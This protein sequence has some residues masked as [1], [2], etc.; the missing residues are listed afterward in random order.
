[1][2]I[3]LKM[4]MKNKFYNKVQKIIP[5][6]SQ[7][8]SK[9]PEL[10][11]PKNWPGFYNKAKGVYVY[12]LKGNKFLDMSIM[13]VGAC[14]LG[15]ADKYV[16]DKVMHSIKKGVSSSLNSIDEFNLAKKLLEI[17]PWFN[18]ARFARSGGEAMEIAV[19]ISR[20]YTKRSI[21]L[22]SGYHGWTDWYLSSNIKDNKNL[23]QYLIKGLNPTGVPTELAGTSIAFDSNN[24]T[25]LKRKIKNKEKKIAAIVIEPGRG[26]FLDTKKIKQIKLI[27][28]EIGA[29]LI[30]DEITSGFRM[31]TG[32]LHKIQ[33]VYPDL[34]VFA[35]GMANGYAMSA[36]LGKGEIM[37]MFNKSFVSST[38]WTERV[39]P[40][41]ALA[42]IEKFQSKN[43]PLKLIS[44]GNEI[45]N[46][47]KET[48]SKA[49]IEI[50]LSGLPSLPSFNIVN[51]DKIFLTMLIDQMLKR[52][53]LSFSQF[54]PSYSHSKKN[55]IDYKKSLKQSLDYISE[56]ENKLIKKTTKSFNSF[57]RL[58]K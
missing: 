39:G 42:T 12:D 40:T 33:K 32:G 45:K 38:N 47:W 46:I 51:K 44:L 23:N 27:A 1:M 7:L 35:K 17:H 13:S 41:A 49:K 31:C 36:I 2:K 52:K 26:D 15:Y 58:T 4:N 56:N 14:T 9:K 22:F 28:K 8:L 57:E 43:V 16:D 30:F 6:G 25:D 11:S 54:R 37:K 55:L 50:T 53:I 29:V 18:M 24:L 3:I 5:G 10:F 21:I 19:R 34:A 48:F 20:A